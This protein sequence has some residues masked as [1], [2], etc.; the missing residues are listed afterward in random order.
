[1]A[2]YLSTQKGKKKLKYE[3][4]YYLLSF[5]SKD[6]STEYWKC[7]NWS[8]KGCPGRVII[9]NGALKLTQKHLEEEFQS[10]IR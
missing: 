9:K 8:S 1:M 3:E 4:F 6:L 7:E 5:K 2:T 10:A